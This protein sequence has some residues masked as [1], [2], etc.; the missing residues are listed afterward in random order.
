VGNGDLGAVTGSISSGASAVG[1][2]R[3]FL[4]E[5]DRVELEGEGVSLALA[6]GGDVRW[7]N[8]ETGTTPAHL[9]LDLHLGDRPL[10]PDLVR[11]G[12]DHRWLSDARGPGALELPY[13]DLIAGAGYFGPGRDAPPGIYVWAIAQTGPKAAPL[14]GDQ[15]DQLRA[16]GYVE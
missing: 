16:L 10:D 4:G 15:I 5:E 7:I 9:R 8:V 1:V 6:S 12:A 2:R 3:F 11:V 13:R 14:T